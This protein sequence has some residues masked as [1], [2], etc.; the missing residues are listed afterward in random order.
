MVWPC[1][2]DALTGLALHGCR[3]QVLRQLVHCRQESVPHTGLRASLP[4]LCSLLE[5]QLL[6]CPHSYFF[7][8]YSMVFFN[9]FSQ[10][11]SVSHS[12]MFDSLLPPW[13]IARQAPVHR[14]LQ[15]R[16]LE[17]GAVP[18]SMGSSQPRD[19]TPVSC[20]AGRFFT[21]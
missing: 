19:R 9:A 16:I 20:I 10:S 12:V 8:K 13:T 11:E 2:K 21:I 18:F 5:M 7:H 3:S 15:A 14:V 4:E 6:L 1:P 17:W